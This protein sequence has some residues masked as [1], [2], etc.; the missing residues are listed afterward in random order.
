MGGDTEIR[1]SLKE[2]VPKAFRTGAVVMEEKEGEWAYAEDVL[3]NLHRVLGPH[4]DATFTLSELLSHICERHLA[5]LRQGTVTRAVICADD[6]RRVPREK[7]ETQQQRNV[8]FRRRTTQQQTKNER[9][10]ADGRTDPEPPLDVERKQ[11]ARELDAKSGEPY[12]DDAQ[13]CAEGIRYRDPTTQEEVVER[14]HLPRLLHSRKVRP[15]IWERLRD[16]LCS[17]EIHVPEGCVL[18]LDHFPEGPWFVTNTRAELRRDLKHNY[19]EGEMMCVY[20]AVHFDQYAMLID[21]IDTDLMPLAVHYLTVSEPARRKPLL[22][23]YWP[24]N[25]VDLRELTNGIFRHYAFS[26]LEFMAR[27]SLSPS[28]S[29]TQTYCVC[30]QCRWRLFCVARITSP[31]PRCSRSWGTSR[32]LLPCSRAARRWS[33][34]TKASSTSSWCCGT[35]TRRF[36]TARPAPRNRP[37]CNARAT[38]RGRRPRWPCCVSRRWRSGTSRFVWRAMPTSSGATPA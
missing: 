16:L 3:T 13:L 32:S 19:G 1:A 4:W 12:P 18:I 5:L 17:G 37:S 8:A 34:S 31:R 28:I 7:Q 9:V 29:Q 38:S 26:S 14:L 22:W 35:S 25:Y 24:T 15:Q 36:S 33:R 6:H 30:V 27:L 23:R 20:W 11:R 21:T 10:L 2:H